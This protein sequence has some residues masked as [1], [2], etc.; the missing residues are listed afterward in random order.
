MNQI[1]GLIRLSCFARHPVSRLPP[2]RFRSGAKWL[3]VILGHR[4]EIFTAEQCPDISRVCERC[5]LME[6][7]CN[8]GGNQ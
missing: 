5:D 4:W 8:D 1:W 6:H 2:S 3:C 7:V